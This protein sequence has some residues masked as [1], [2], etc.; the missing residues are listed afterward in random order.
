MWDECFGVEN[1]PISAQR[2]ELIKDVHRLQTDIYNPHIDSIIVSNFII[3]ISVY[4]AHS[5]FCCMHAKWPP[6][7]HA[8][9]DDTTKCTILIRYSMFMP[10]LFVCVWSLNVSCRGKIRCL[11]NLQLL[12]SHIRLV[13][14]CLDPCSSNVIYA[15]NV[16]NTHTEM[17]F[18]GKIK[19]NS[20]FHIGD[21]TSYS[22]TV[23]G[24]DSHSSIRNRLNMCIDLPEKVH[25]GSLTCTILCNLLNLEF[26]THSPSK[27]RKIQKSLV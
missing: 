23:V 8:K 2:S 11:P 22:A 20:I 19:M 27:R 21:K 3:I 16:V 18:S 1:K 17:E 10:T 9:N 14:D 24:G 7:W 12:P 5:Y 25:R 15:Q 4:R 6:N 26:C 13:I